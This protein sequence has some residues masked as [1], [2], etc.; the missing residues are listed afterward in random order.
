[1]ALDRT[2]RSRA[3]S[4][5][6]PAVIF[7]L[8]ALAV[9][10][11]AGSPARAA[12]PPLSV[13]QSGP[14]GEVSHIGHASEVRVVFSEPMVA[15]GRIP[16]RFVPPYFKIQP[17]VEGTFRWSDTKTLIFTAA[18]PLPFAT[19]FTV[20]VDASAVSSA[21]R[22]LEK[23]HTFS[24]TTPTVRLLH[25]QWYRVGNVYT[26]PVVLLLR[27]NQ[28]VKPEVA[29]L[30]L[31]LQYQ[32]HE[33][34]WS[35]PTLDPGLAARLAKE[36]PKSLQDFQAKVAQARAS[37][38]GS[39]AVHT[40]LAQEWDKKAFPP[41]GDL[42]VL[43][44]KTVPPTDAW[45]KILVKETIPSAA[46][47]ATPGKVDSKTVRLEPTFF[48][49]GFH[50]KSECDPDG[51]NPL[52]LTGSVR[53]S[54]LKA[55]FRAWDVTE[56]GKETLL[57]PV[58]GS[59]DTPEETEYFGG[60]GDYG[61]SSGRRS[62][63]NADEMGY[64]FL[65]GRSYLCRVDRTLKAFDGQTLG[66]TWMG[67]ME[68]GL[69]PA[70]VS[71]DGGHGVWESTGGT[72]LP[73]HAK[74]L[75]DV[76]QWVQ[77]LRVEELVP[78]M[79]KLEVRPTLPPTAEGVEPEEDWNFVPFRLAPPGSGT[80][81]KLNPKP[82]MLQAYGLELR[83]ALGPEGKGLL[84]AALRAG[85]ALPRSRGPS[86]PLPRASLVQVTNLGLTVKDSPH[87]VLVMVTR[88]DDGK[89]VEGAQVAIRDLKNRV[90]WEGVTD[91]D[92]V[93]LAPAPAQALRNPEDWWRLS[94]VVTAQK[95]GD[96]AYLASDWNEG[97]EPW[98]FGFWLDL[99]EAKP[100]LRGDL[101]ADRGVYKLGEEVH[102]KGVFRS[103]T[104]TGMKLLEKGT[105]VALVLRD[106]QDKEL[107]K[108]EVSLNAW[109]AWDGTFKLPEE[110]A[111]GSYR[112]TAE[113]AGQ[114]RSVSGSFLVAAY[115]RP[116]FRVDAVL[117]G[118][119]ALA[120]AKLRGSVS[121]RY[122]FGAPM[123]KKEVK[124]TYS[125]MVW[126]SVPNAV[127][128]R[129]PG[130]R[131]EFLT[132]GWGG[133]EVPGD[134]TLLEDEGTLDA[135][136]QF[137]LDLD[138]LLKAGVPV[139]YMLEG[140]VTDTTRQT[141]ANRA[142]FLVHPA[143]WYIGVSRPP[144]FAEPEKGLDSEFVAVAPDGSATA[145]VKVRVTLHQ[146]QWHS[147]RRA[148]GQGFY[149]WETERKEVERG[150]WEVV[151]GREP[152]PLHIPL[153]SG[154]YFVLKARAE[155]AEGRFTTTS[156]DFYACGSGYTAWE[157]Y[158]H[159]RIDLVSEKTTYKPGETARILIK[160]P[161]EKATALL[162]TER[163]GIKSH[164]RFELTSSQQTVSVPVTEED[165]PNVF[166]SVM[167]VKGRTE[168]FTDKD[169]S[170]PGKPSYR[171]GCIE[172]KVDDG[173]KRLSCTVASDKEEYRP[174][175]KAKLAVEVKDVAGRPVQ[176]EVTLWAVDY[177]VLSLTA[178]KTPSLADDVWVPKALQ[179]LTEDSRERIVS[180]R[181]LTP[182]G[183]DEGGGGGY[184]EGGDK[185]FRKD[186]RVLAF[187]LGSLPTDA[188]GKAVAEVDLPEALTTYRVMAVV[189]DRASRFGWAQ[190]EIRLSQPV[191]LKAA[192]PRF[193]AVGDRAEFGSVVHSQ[194]KE[195]GT[196]LV[197]MKSLD[198]GV[199]E[200]QGDP[201]R[202]LE[203]PAK[204]SLEVRYPVVAK[205]PGKARIQT[206]VQ[207][208]GESDAFEDELP[209]EILVTPEV[210]AAY[211]QASPEAQETLEVPEGVVP[212]SGGL[213][214]D[215][216]ST[217]MVGLG[218]GA[219]YLVDYPYGCAEQRSSCA[220]ALIL[221]S[222][223]GGAFSLPGIEPAKLRSVAQATLKD[224]EAYQCDNGGFVYWKGDS[225][226]FASAYLTSYVLHVYQRAQKLGYTVGPSVMEKGYAFLENA[227]NQP[228]PQDEGWFPGYT[229]WQ[230]FA[231]KVLAEGGRNVDS[232][233]TRL[234][235]YLDRMPVF[236]ISYLADA[237]AAKG[238]KG[239]RV[240]ELVRR[241]EN[242]VLT[243]AGASHVEELADP[244]LLWFWNS[245][246]RS[247]ALVLGSLVRNTDRATLVPSLVR[248][249]LQV[250]RH[251]R[252]GNTQENAIAMEAL[253]DYYRKYEKEVPDFTAL[254]T[255]GT[256]TLL[257]EPF[258]GRTTDS[259]SRAV[260]MAD[261]LARGAGR[262]LPLGFK[263]EGTGTLF[264]TARLKYA[265]DTTFAEGLDQ[266][267]R[268]S[269]R[270]EPYDEK[271]PESRLPETTQFKAGAL[272]RV[273]LTLELP[274]ERRWVAAT[275]PLPAGF[276][277]VE[278][279]FATTGR[280]LARASE[281]MG[282][283]GG[284][285]ISYWKRGGFNRTERH[286]DRVLVFAT[287]LGAGK[288][289]FSYLARATT[290]GSFRVAPARAEEMYT[291]EIFGRTKT[292]TVEVKP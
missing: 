62:E 46:G 157:R 163:E 243:E 38:L 221:A 152:V 224:L 97:L 271:K 119:S 54:D 19:T 274:K 171:M 112:V 269:R 257:T 41:S 232:A 147:V 34:E 284:D 93:Y 126:R 276:E 145:G 206:T 235:G 8:S 29:A 133:P 182:K 153:P 166:V 59:A 179:V 76:V 98:S 104:A 253:V 83:S 187:W 183:G 26:G 156:T 288:H 249:L 140:E 53:P 228:K 82:G 94:F 48:V 267:I 79:L 279:W 32:P 201:K 167:L 13:V 175:D 72:L 164:R 2:R 63:V 281:S 70:F 151:T 78:A 244:Y 50:C 181:V 262:T 33:K 195:K 23:P 241:M 21:G 65:A 146:V 291:P 158:D 270:Y 237:H 139:Q 47:P 230:A 282:S 210:V 193:L 277:A 290:L 197:T 219:R 6:S 17:A 196:A 51:Y 67:R 275:D 227:L 155:D 131:W 216:S 190:R 99:E 37:V 238:A 69:G 7:L 207:L 176:G 136:G 66:Y 111:L 233:L 251:G 61:Y 129:F 204:G 141:I 85:A 174:K 102:V 107:A 169:A 44:T 172:L 173:T 87:N 148:E 43:Q 9:G 223:L 11:V 115:R 56:T 16:E 92:G 64:N 108:R 205:G 142:S 123:A 208:L 154:G 84:W 117:G 103:D 159:N 218:E 245:N 122:L 240:D 215:L 127:A 160:S 14:N 110:G 3:L 132:G 4:A 135:S 252:W 91:R 138:T 162:T 198:P 74:N 266:G 211:G 200:V 189:H 134:S 121:G 81:R 278:S 100:L 137:A 220:L 95:D 285:W 124:V 273:V 185:R 213:R 203:V 40:F 254:V 22:R 161:W 168:S 144:F 264:Y 143:P 289:E 96:T 118:E 192:F 255:L 55:S 106:S 27:F 170:D 188:N 31:G 88:L 272:V 30:H 113:V 250:R 225:C 39:G 231:A 263:R 199:L 202:T 52:N 209:V 24:F 247:T 286:D 180:R 248:W 194:L 15:L 258:K 212:N 236:G 178:Y 77:P 256:E 292:D 35:A 36:D 90:V 86:A 246:P 149:A 128:D 222:D 150:S 58:E 239:P 114:G 116:D 184:E 214:V 42:V 261:L 80:P 260:G 226:V 18:K 57:K 75:L 105:K 287:R 25:A 5:P 280:D 101:F 191:L 234:G 109:S 229:A 265:L 125:R 12:A 120:G 60:D 89:P 130:E 71:F 73:F 283:G 68:N 10:F 28:P 20:T 268:I 165:V 242:A 45:I 186:F 1:M 259:K 177:G 217:A 49:T